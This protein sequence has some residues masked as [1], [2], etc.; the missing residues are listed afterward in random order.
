MGLVVDARLHGR[1]RLRRRQR[2][3]RCDEAVAAARSVGHVANTG[4]ALAQGL[5]QTGDVHTQAALVDGDIRPYTRDQLFLADDLS[6][7]LH[8]DDED[9]E[10]T[11]AQLERDS[12]PF[13]TPP[14]RRQPKRAK[15]ND[16][17]R[18]GILGRGEIASHA[19]PIVGGKPR[20][21]PTC[22]RSV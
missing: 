1:H 19:H 18:A 3:D 13:D 20:Q 7:V 14:R 12:S 17:L 16:V 5:A 15:H 6:G 22:T 4:L 8:Q 11:A 21:L 9:V 10:R 2:S